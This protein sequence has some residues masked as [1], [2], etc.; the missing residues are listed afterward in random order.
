MMNNATEE[1]EALISLMTQP[2]NGQY[3]RPWMSNLQD[4]LQAQ[5]FVVGMN[6][7]KG[8]P[9]DRVGSHSRHMDALYNRNEQRCRAIYDEITGGRP[10]PTRV[11]IDHLMRLL[12]VEGITKVLETNVVCYSTP[13]SQYLAHAVHLDGA[14]AGE[15]IFRTLLSHIRPKVLIAHGAGTSKRLSKMIGIELPS[16]PKDARDLRLLQSTLDGYPITVFVVP[17][18]APPHW[19]SWKGWAKSHLRLIAESVASLAN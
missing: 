18:L 12:A 9:V 7:A 4:P 17:S 8:F 1:F 15:Q 3:P 14:K 2:V 5:V 10:S 13:M 6:Q 19:N 11:N 16:P